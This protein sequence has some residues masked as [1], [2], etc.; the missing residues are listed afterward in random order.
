MPRKI[1]LL[2]S[3]KSNNLMSDKVLKVVG[4]IKLY[5]GPLGKT[6]SGSL[7]TV[8]PLMEPHIKSCLSKDE[9]CVSKDPTSLK[10]I[11]LDGSSVYID[12]SVKNNRK[13]SMSNPT[14]DVSSEKLVIAAGP[15]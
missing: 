3:S 9:V 4:G 2:L 13:S 7:K 11:G 1:D 10:G 8:S 12:G 14:M 15:S 5:I 6:F